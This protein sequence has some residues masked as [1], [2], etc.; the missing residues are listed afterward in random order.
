MTLEEAQKV[1]EICSE[2]DGGCSHCTYE[3]MLLCQEAFP[4]FVWNQKEYEGISVRETS[5]DS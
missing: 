5:S 2:A 1:A 4:E 3:L